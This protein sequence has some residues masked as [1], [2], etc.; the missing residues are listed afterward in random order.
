[1]YLVYIIV[2]DNLSYVGMTNNFLNRW[3]QHNG[4][5]KGGAK[6]TKKK[7]NWYPICIID[8]FKNKSEAM[9]CEWKVKSRKPKLS[10][11]FKGGKGRVE[12]LNLLLGDKRWTSNSPLIK[13]QDL[14]VYVDKEY[15]HLIKCVATEEL[16]W[17]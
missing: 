6:Y 11:Q 9:Q 14:T 1:M 15:E 10:R 13:E 16:Y 3:Q 2:C 5:L 7:Y 8:G 12:Y 17:K 4:I